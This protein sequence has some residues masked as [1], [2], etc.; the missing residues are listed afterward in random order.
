MSY[1]SATMKGNIYRGTTYP[2]N[3]SLN[4]RHSVNPTSC[5]S[6]GPGEGHV[7]NQCMVD[8]DT[9][10]ADTHRGHVHYP[11]PVYGSV[12]VKDS[13]PRPQY[14]IREEYQQSPTDGWYDGG[15]VCCRGV[16][17]MRNVLG[18][19]AYADYRATHRHICSSLYVFSI[20][21]TLTVLLLLV[22][23]SHISTPLVAWDHQ[24]LAIS[25]IADSIKR[26]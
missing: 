21:M 15:S 12:P 18:V 1:G 9:E 14:V 19:H 26:I 7:R 2:L 16:E 23:C 10:M 13:L 17:T 11:A 22:S 5:M 8:N 24:T 20:R 25:R 6:C 3:P 4:H